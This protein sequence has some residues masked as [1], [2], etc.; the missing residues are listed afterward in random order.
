LHSYF[1]WNQFAFLHIGLSFLAQLSPLAQSF[2]EQISGG[3]VHHIQFLG[4]IDGLS[5]FAGARRAQKNN[6]QVHSYLMKPS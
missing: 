3:D 1:I 6:V 2:S 5:A 4:Y